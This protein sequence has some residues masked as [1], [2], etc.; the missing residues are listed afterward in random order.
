MKTVNKFNSCSAGLFILILFLFSSCQNRC[1]KGNGNVTT[2]VR[3]IADFTSIEVSSALKVIFTQGPVYKVEV[4]ADDNFIG[5]ITTEVKNGELQIGIKKMKCFNKVTN[6]EIHITAPVLTGVEVSGAS[7]FESTNLIEGQ[8]IS[9]SLS[10]SST[11]RLNVKVTMFNA[12]LSGASKIEVTGV[13]KDL[14]INGSGA[15]ELNAI[16]LKGQ[17]ASI[18]FSGSSSGTIS[19]LGNLN[20]T[21]SGA[22]VLNYYGS[23]IVTSNLS[24]SSSLNKK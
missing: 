2:E 3:S 23:P 13:T 11:M 5:Y 19:V 7:V 20:A 14:F 9:S 12:E 8:N 22:S 16:G 21:L 4:V 10:G 15:S 1:I 6:A 18:D 17:S 24:G